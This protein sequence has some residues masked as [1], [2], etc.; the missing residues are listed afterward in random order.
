MAA[1]GGGTGSSTGSLP[2]QAAEALIRYF[3][4]AVALARELGE[5]VD[6]VLGSP[7]PALPMPT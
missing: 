5:A 7:M 1:L 4:A 2:G 6:S 3:D